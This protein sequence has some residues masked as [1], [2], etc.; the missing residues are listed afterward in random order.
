MSTSILSVGIDIGTTT[1]QVI[2]SRLAMENVSAYFAVPRVEIVDKRVVYKSAIHFTPLLSQTALDG[3]GVRR[4]VE[5]EFRKAGFSPRDT[6]TGAVIITGEAARKENAGVVLDRMS[7]MAG[8][9]VVSTAGPDLESII[10]GKGSG[11]QKHSA[12]RGCRV[13]NL[14]IGGG[15][16]NIAVF[17][18]GETIA[19]GC[20]DI[21]GRLIRLD[22]AGRIDY[23]SPK[24]ALAARE[25]GVTLTLGGMADA[26]AIRR[27]AGVMNRV[28][29]EAMGIAAPSPLLEEMRTPGS[30][31]LRLEGP[32]DAVCFSGGVADC[33]YRP[34][35]EPFPY[36]DMGALLAGAIAAGRLPKS[37]RLF[38]PAETI[39]ATVIGAGT[40]TTT[41][42]GSTITYT[43]DVFPV[44]NLPVLVPSA[45]V[46]EALYRG[47]AGP[48]AGAAEWFLRQNDGRQ[49]VLGLKGWDNPS[50]VQLAAAA[51]AIVAALG[52]LLPPV[53]PVFVSVERDIA[54]ALGQCLDSRLGGARQVVCIDG[55]QLRD[56]D[57]LD[58]GNPLM[59][60]MVIPVI[61]KTL[62]FG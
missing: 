59:G 20:L 48:L 49:L 62:V 17:D 7:G 54:K 57:F 16:T 3:D 58:M 56:G 43:A 2:F 23:I 37:M 52:G 61:V 30:S 40:Y 55:I 27:V 15:T 25:A 36:G 44:K 46:E 19:T 53:A 60:G 33:I 10:A 14:D 22:R 26:N 18:A 21:G 11:A 12:E 39:R 8:D 50:Y 51:D 4:I 13:A 28:L 24:A 5:E 6:D 34:C 45:A 42:S 38:E 29:E 32:V 9:F 31:R 1:T 35:R 41:V 47:E